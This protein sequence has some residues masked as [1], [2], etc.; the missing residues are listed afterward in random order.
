MAHLFER[1]TQSDSPDNRRHDGLGLGLSI[2][3]NLAELHGGS[4]RAESGGEGLGATFHV[5]LG[6]VPA[7]HSPIVLLDTQAPVQPA[8]EHDHHLF[9][10]LD[11]LLVEDNADA[12]EVLIVVL[13][14]AG[15]QVRHA[16]DCETALELL[17]QKWPDVLVSDIG[18]PGRD[19]YDLIREVRRLEAEQGRS[20]TP[21]IAHTAFTRAMDH[22]KATEAGFDAHVGKPLQPHALLGAISAQL[23]R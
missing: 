6:V 18:L 7:G 8:A 21:A 10:G 12:S 3:K 5:T 19:G 16:A 23:P 9:S 15:A 2:V 11:I 13:S 14:D 22:E 20:R 1:F 4:V 17:R